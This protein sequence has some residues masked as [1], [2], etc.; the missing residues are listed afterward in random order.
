G[1]ITFTNIPGATNV[2]YTFTPALSDSGKQYRA[3]F[4]NSCGT[5]PSSSAN[6]T[7]N[8]RPTAVVSGG[9]IICTGNSTNVQA[10]LSGAA[11][12]SVVWSDGFTTNNVPSSPLTRTVSPSSTTIYTVTSVT[13]A[14]GCTNIGSGSA[15]VTVNTPASV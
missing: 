13:D 10:A 9:G 2:T 15:T 3:V 1:G 5:V 6:L 4:T 12:W 7:V 11:P 8:A 14:N